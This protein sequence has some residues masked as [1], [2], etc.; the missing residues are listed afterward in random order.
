MKLSVNE[1]TGFWLWLYMCPYS[2]SFDF[3]ICLRARKVSGRF[4]ACVA[5]VSA[6]VR[7]EGWDKNKKKGMTFFL[8]PLQLSRYNSTANAF[9]AG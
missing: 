9:Y 6:R 5:S 8:L 4:V 2:T 7:R 3:K 1:T